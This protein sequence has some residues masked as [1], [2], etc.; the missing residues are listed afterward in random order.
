V[1]IFLVGF[2]GVGKSYWAK[3]WAQKINYACYDTD[4]MIEAQQQQSIVTIFETKGEFFFRQQEADVLR[5]FSPIKNAIISCGGGMP[6]YHSNMQWMNDNGMT[7]FLNAP[8]N[9]LQQNIL[10]QPLKRPLLIALQPAELLVSIETKL[11]ER[12]PIYLQSKLVLDATTITE[13]SID[14]IIKNLAK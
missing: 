6:C 10:S 1:K 5:S 11:E 14:T 2:M 12:L 8:A 7:V 13:H 9:Y 3:L 4:E